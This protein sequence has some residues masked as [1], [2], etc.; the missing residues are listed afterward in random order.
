[1][2]SS[3][4]Q[5]ARNQ[6]VFREVNENVA[7]L[8]GL[9]TEVGYNLFICECSDTSCAESLEITA[10]EYEG[11]RAQGTRFVVVPGHELEAVERVVEGNRRFLV[12]EKLGPAAEIADAADP[13]RS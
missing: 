4:E 12:V 10:A 9:V 11:V 2:A 7:K 1:M 6:T 8:T 13:R 5:A 3:V